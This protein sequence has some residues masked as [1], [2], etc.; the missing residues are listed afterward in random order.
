MSDNLADE[1]G[2]LREQKNNRIYGN[3]ANQVLRSSSDD[4]ANIRIFFKYFLLFYLITTVRRNFLR[5][6]FNCLTSI[7]YKAQNI[8]RLELRNFAVGNK[9]PS[10]SHEQRKNRWYISKWYAR[11]ISNCHRRYISFRYDWYISKWYGWYIHSAA[12]MLYS[13]V[14]IAVWSFM[15]TNRTLS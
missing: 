8:F 13:P 7:T 11:Y 9:T 4:I 3:A 10:A 5:Q 15:A 2:I 14:I 6:G 1:F 12:I